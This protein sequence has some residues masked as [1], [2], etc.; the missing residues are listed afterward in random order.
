ME[1]QRQ[2]WQFVG[3]LQDKKKSSKANPSLGAPEG[4][5]M[6]CLLKQ[7]YE[8]RTFGL[9]MFF[10]AVLLITSILLAALGLKLSGIAVL[11]TGWV[12]IFIR[13]WLFSRETKR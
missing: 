11:T 2:N 6:P 13:M 8:G 4:F 3:R 1:T 7:E 5:S 9:Q 12:L 10:A